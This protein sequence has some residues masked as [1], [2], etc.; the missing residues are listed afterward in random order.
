MSTMPVK[1]SMVNEVFMIAFASHSS[2]LP[3]RIEN[4]GAPPRP[5]KLEKAVMI[6]ISGK[7]RP[8]APSA[9]VPTFGMRAM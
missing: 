4:K 7:H 9:A 1:Q 2:F 3:L 5:Y 6:T 8:T